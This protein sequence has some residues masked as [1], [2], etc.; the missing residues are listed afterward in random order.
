M[1]SVPVGGPGTAVYSLDRPRPDQLIFGE[2][3]S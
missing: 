1:A 3:A 2:R